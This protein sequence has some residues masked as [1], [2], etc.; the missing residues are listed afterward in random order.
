MTHI[1][2]CELVLA[3]NMIHALSFVPESKVEMGFDLVAEEICSV[4]TKLDISQSDLK[5]LDELTAYFQKKI[6]LKEIN[7]PK[8]PLSYFFTELLFTGGWVGD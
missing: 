1:S 5:K 3:L 8:N 6:T 2:N 7:W 4:A